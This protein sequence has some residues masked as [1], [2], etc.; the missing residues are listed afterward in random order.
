MNLLTEFHEDRA[1]NVAPRPYIYSHIGKN[2]PPLGS[3]VFQANVTIF[4]LIHD[5]IETNHLT[6]FHEDWTIMHMLTAHDAQRSKSN[7]KSSPLFVVLRKFPLSNIYILTK[8]HKDWMKTVTSTVYTN[9]LLTDT[10]TTH[11][12]H[13]TIT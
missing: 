6:K 13:H 1:I 12:E 11:T 9:K 10:R 7:H 2:A 3:H 5:I 4:V 8:F